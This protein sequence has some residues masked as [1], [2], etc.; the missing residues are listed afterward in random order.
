[1]WINVMFLICTI[2]KI[3]RNHLECWDQ[4]GAS[5]WSCPHV[6]CHLFLLLLLT[7]QQAGFVLRCL[8]LQRREGGFTIPYLIYKRQSIISLQSFFSSF[9]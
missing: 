6:F 5:V 8:L 1:M 7:V 3:I 4:L 2:R 9:L